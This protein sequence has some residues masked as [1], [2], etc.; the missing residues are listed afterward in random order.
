MRAVRLHGTGDVRLHEEPDTRPGE[1][2]SLVRV[3]AVGL[4]GSDLHWFADGGIGDARIADPVVPGHE[5]FGTAL[6]GAYAG[7][8]VVVDPAISCL[9][10]EYCFRGDH[11]LCERIIFAGHGTRDGGMQD[12]ISWP[13]R[14]LTPLPDSIDDTQAVALEPLG[15]AIHAVDLS[16]LKPGMR[17]GVVGAGPI[18]LFILQLARNANAAEVVV[19]EPR[20]HR[21]RLATR[22]GADVAVAPGDVQDHASRCDLVFEVNGNPDAVAEAITLARAGSR[23]VL[24]GIPDEDQTTFSAS[25]A[26]RKGLTLVCVRRMKEVYERAIALVERGHVDAAAVVSDVFPLEQAEAAFRSGVAREGHKVVVKL[27]DSDAPGS[28]PLQVR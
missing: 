27:S 17:I 16:H 25:Q 6:T 8:R 20:E 5:F 26:R 18:G 22:L 1:G 19:V 15:V 21:R 4:C 2:E 9:E 13:D 7:R 11:N 14:S 28:R 3:H 23:V 12:L 24:V 10:C